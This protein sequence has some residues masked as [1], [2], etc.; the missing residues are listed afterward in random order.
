MTVESGHRRK[1]Q[2]L[3]QS[4]RSKDAKILI[5]L[6]ELPL[7]ER[8]ARVADLTQQIQHAER[9]LEKKR[10]SAAAMTQKK[11]VAL[12]ADEDGLMELKHRLA[13]EKSEYLVQKSITPDGDTASD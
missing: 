12:L 13:L 11:R 4:R 9:A 7:A 6:K 8:A 1:V 2:K 10:A 3:F 5:G